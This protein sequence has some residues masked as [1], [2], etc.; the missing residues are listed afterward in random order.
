MSRLIITLKNPPQ[1]I[2]RPLQRVD[3]GYSPHL[4]AHLYEL[5]HRTLLAYMN[6]DFNTWFIT[7]STNCNTRVTVRPAHSSSYGVTAGVEGLSRM[8]VLLLQHVLTLEGRKSAV[9]HFCIKGIQTGGG[10]SR[11]VLSPA[12]SLTPSVIA[13]R[14]IW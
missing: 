3:R 9:K 10:A 4:L 12:E 5:A 6:V 8:P 1:T 7:S 13:C 14:H 11:L 2:S